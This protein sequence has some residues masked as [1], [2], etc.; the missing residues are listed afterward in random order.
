MVTDKKGFAQSIELPYGTYTVKETKVPDNVMP[1]EDF[2]VVVT[3]DSREPQE[4]R[5]F[6]DAPFKALIKAI[7]VDQD[8]GKNVLLAGTEFKIKNLHTNEYVGHWVW[9]PIPHYVDTFTTDESGTVT[10]PNVLEAAEYQLEEISSPFGYILNE[11]PIRFT[12]SAN[13]AYEIAEDGKTPVIMVTKEDKAVQGKISVK[14]VGEQLVSI[15]KD[16]NGNIQFIYEDK[17]VNG[18]EFII[19]AAQDIRSPDNQGNIIYKKGEIVDKISTKNGNGQSK[20]LPLG[21]YTVEES[22]AG[23]SFVLNK[24]IHEVELKYKDQHTE[25]VFNETQ[26]KNERQK[27]EVNV[28]K[29]DH[30]NGML[31]S[32]AEF[33]LYAK[34]DI[35]TYD[36]KKILVKAGELIER[37]KTNNEGKATFKADLPLSLFEIKEIHA[38]IGY[39][40]TDQSIEIDASYQGQDKEIIEFSSIF[41]NEITQ[42]EISKKDATTGEELPGAHLTIKEKNGPIFETWISTNEPHIV[43]GLE[44]GKTYELIETSSPY[45]FAI[46]QKIEFTIEDTGKLQKVEMIDEMVMGKLKWQKT[47]KVFT[48]TI[49]GQ[50][51][52]GKVETPVFE[53]KEIS[54]AEIS[55]Y[56]ADDITLANGITYYQK[57]QLIQTLKSGSEPV[58]SKELPVGKYYYM[59]SVVPKP[60]VQ[61][62]DKHYFEIKDNQSDEIQIIESK[63][64]NIRAKVTFNLTKIME[65]HEYYADEY[66]D[67]YKNVA[68]GIF[69]RDNI[70]NYMDEIEISKDT[71]IAACSIDENGHLMNVP[72]LPIGKFYLKELSTDENYIISND[73][74]DF[75]IKYEGKDV[76]E[77]TLDINEGKEIVNQ[78]K[79]TDI[80]IS[81]I[82]KITQEPLANVEFTLYD[83][84]MN[85]IAKSLSNN[86]GVARFDK[87]P[88]GVYFCKETKALDGYALSDEVI[89]IE[90][91]GNS[92]NNEYHVT[93]TNVLLP[94]KSENIQ[95]GDFTNIGIWISSIVV[96]GIVVLATL[97]LHKKKNDRK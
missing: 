30:D 22:I 78:L 95:T 93:M 67:A 8:T 13:T 57:D 75:E 39:A 65:E 54:N 14:K 1:V 32:G 50:N 88:N 6:N 42:T 7:K 52:F 29:K 62:L 37:A 10:T 73:E 38:P 59:E 12:V 53:E 96:S 68:F 80:V 89:K 35:Y 66:K 82:D 91:T 3:E 51:E 34:K 9:F 83:K 21:K 86:E 84:D 92:K 31:L 85:E 17:E 77:I 94:A 33:G 46:S 20:L 41:E 26:Y 40:S 63:L 47:G 70:L 16:D 18:A 90:L 44:F 81:K 43:K 72:D 74:Y 28:I 55:I 97:R 45:G 56:A 36:S 25:V 71:M 11:E 76:Q 48:H 2:T 24:E 49:T 61:S 15:E 58:E 23:N 87:L 19:K 64:E 5:V 69:A 60:F 4:W 27:A 79:R